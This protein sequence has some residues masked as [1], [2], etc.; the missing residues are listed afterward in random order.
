MTMLLSISV[1]PPLV[2]LFHY[3]LVITCYL[4]QGFLIVSHPD[5]NWKDEIM[6]TSTY[7]K[8]AI[9]GMNN[10]DLPLTDDQANILDNLKPKK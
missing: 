2:L 5:A 1:S 9:V 8:T 6:C 7:L 3:S 10:N 4:M